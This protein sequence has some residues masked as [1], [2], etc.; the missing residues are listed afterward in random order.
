M[1]ITHLILLS[2]F[3]WA[4]MIFAVFDVFASYSSVLRTFLARVQGFSL[5]VAT[6]NSTALKVNSMIEDIFYL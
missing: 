4:L 5:M 2:D 1:Y 3:L 6:Y